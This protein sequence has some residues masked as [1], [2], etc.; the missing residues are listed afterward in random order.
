MNDTP[1]AQPA[2]SVPAIIPEKKRL[3]AHSDVAVY[4]T[5]AFEQMGRLAA[6][7]ADSWMLPETI[8]HD[9]QGALPVETIRARAFMIIAEARELGIPPLA[10]GQ[11]CSWIK[12]R[13]AKEG[14]LVNAIVRARTGI[15]LAFEFGLWDVHHFVAV[16][17]KSEL[18][19]A[20]ERLSIRCYDPARPEREVT[21]SV[22]MWRTTGAGSP[23]SSPN[24]WRRQLRYR[25][26]PEWARAFEPG[27]ILGISTDGEDFGDDIAPTTTKPPRVTRGTAAKLTQGAGEAAASTDAGGGPGGFD[28]DAVDAE[29][30]TAAE[31]TETAEGGGPPAAG[32]DGDGL[33]IEPGHAA[34]GEIYLRADSIRLETGK[35]TTFK[36]GS[37]FSTKGNVDGLKVY[38]E[39]PPEVTPPVD[40]D[41][42]GDNDQPCEACGAAAGEDCAPDCP[43]LLAAEAEEE[44]G[45][46][47]ARP[48]AT[49]GAQPA[50]PEPDTSETATPASDGGAGQAEA[51]GQSPPADDASPPGDEE[52][53]H[54]WLVDGQPV[55]ECAECGMPRATTE[56]EAAQG[57]SMTPAEEAAAAMLGHMTSWLEFKPSIAKMKQ[58]SDW[59]AASPQDQADAHR[60]IWGQVLRI[61]AAPTRDPVDH[62]EDVT[63]FNI[64]MDTQRGRDGADAV[65]GTFRGITTA[66]GGPWANMKPENQAKV[67]ARVAAF[68]KS[69]RG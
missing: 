36:D 53:E 60:A 24:D 59:L 57:E 11:C 45:E 46:A 6:V 68:I 47:D 23:W 29:F 67:E 5:A 69:H 9:K 34:P 13:L 66:K 42:E 33:P 14:K 41:A 49:G 43:D 10:Y 51:S 44:A 61:K 31:T 32:T 27:A 25:A 18:H 21:G 19:G 37:R 2:A 15:E 56:A 8:T 39:D 16:A 35:R 65:E 3:V 55:A 22:G 1:T 63:A 38:A 62:G 7:M 4:D 52:C 28:K 48:T 26:V 17:D 54:V 64:W 12:G 20:G 40:D 30:T 58:T 50:E